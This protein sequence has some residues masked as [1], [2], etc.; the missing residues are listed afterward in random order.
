MCV[1]FWDRVQWVALRVW[2]CLRDCGVCCTGTVDMCVNQSWRLKSRRRMKTHSAA[3]NHWQSHHQQLHHRYCVCMCVCVLFVILI[4]L[5]CALDHTN[6]VIA[7]ILRYT[8]W[9]VYRVMGF[10]LTVLL[11]TLWSSSLLSRTFLQ[12]CVGVCGSVPVGLCIMYL[13]ESRE[14]FIKYGWVFLLLLGRFELLDKLM[15]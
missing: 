4:V 2:S 8:S 1:C 12:V 6:V 10:P 9:I 11:S 5:I 7:D 15:K 3:E 13:S 14:V